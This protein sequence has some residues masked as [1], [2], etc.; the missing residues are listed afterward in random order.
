M[1][2]IKS[3]FD[4]DVLQND[5]KLLE[6]WAKRWK[7]YFNVEKCKVISIS[8]AHCYMKF[9]YYVDGQSLTRVDSIIELGDTLTT[10]NLKNGL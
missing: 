6:I 9:K 8:K 1:R 4:S 3:T 2:K 7:M 10:I 5:L